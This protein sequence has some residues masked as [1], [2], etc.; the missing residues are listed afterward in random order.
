M[1]EIDQCIGSI[2]LEH[3]SALPKAD[4]NSTAPSRQRHAVFRSL[5]SD[6]IKQDSAITTS[7]CKHSISFLKEK[8]ILA[9]SF[10]T[11]WENTDGCDEQYRYASALYLM[12]V[13]YQS[14]SII[15][16]Q[17]ISAPG[18]GE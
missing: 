15:I 18:H 16:D 10:S 17:G 11:I 2:T 12:S 1:V 7:H 6:N 14:Y 5:L 4:M 13:M 3:V 9:T 8:K